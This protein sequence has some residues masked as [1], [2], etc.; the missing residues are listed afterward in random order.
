[1]TNNKTNLFI[2]DDNKLMVADLSHYL[3]NRF[4]ESLAISTFET[5]ELCLK[6][7]T[8]ETDLVILDYYLEG[9]N[10][11]EILKSIKK[12]SPRT[13]V[14]VLSA[15]E[16]MAIAIESFR[17]GATDYVVKGKGSWRKI[18][19][20]VSHILTAPVRLLVREFGVSKFMAAFITVFLTM[21]IIVYFVV[22]SMN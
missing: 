17:R 9:K 4:G 2:V 5:G 20:V 10:G 1:M 7:V 13:E 18:T 16:D 21:G 12:I 22:Q 19:G 14:V 15:N 11:L 3:Q 8:T 6:Q